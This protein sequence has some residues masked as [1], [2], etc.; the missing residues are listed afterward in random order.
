M[1][2]LQLEKRKF[3]I[4]V[5]AVLVVMIYLVRLLFLQVFSDDYK[6][7][8]DSNAFLKKIQYPARGLITDR[9]G[10]LM[11]YNE[12]SYNMMVIM[13][14][15]KGHIDT[16]EFCKALGI[17]PEFYE[18]R[19]AEIKDRSKNPGYSRFTQ[20]LFMSQLSE[21]DFSIFQEKLFRFPGFYVQKRSIRQYQYPYAAH[22]LGDVAEVSDYD[23]EDDDY[24]QAGDYIG[25]LGV[26]RYYEKALRSEKGVKI[27][28]ST[29]ED[30]GKLQ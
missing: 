18:Q 24:Y 9:N 7:Y 2:A 22:V 6:R 26:E 8:A 11:V 16:L 3:T 5:V 19:M 17:T 28:L 20:Q 14:E 10:R 15:Q 4:G 23:I 30:K 12:P 25:K 21:R 27:M 1:K 13:N 29:R